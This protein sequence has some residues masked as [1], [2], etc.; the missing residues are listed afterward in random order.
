MPGPVI[1]FS[2]EQADVHHRLNTDLLFFAKHAPLLIKGKRP[3]EIVPWT[4][5]VGQRYLHDRLEDQIRRKGWVRVVVPKGRQVGVSTYVQMRFYH[6]VRSN[7][8]MSAFILS[9]EGKT[10]AKIF[11]MAEFAHDNIQAALRPEVGKSNVNQMTFP[12]LGSDYAVGTAGNENVGRGGTAQLFH[13]SEAAYWEHDYAI[14]DGALE[15]IGLVP[16]TEIILESTGNGP[17][18]LFYDKCQMALRTPPQGVYE[19]VFIPWYW[20]GDYEIADDPMDPAEL[21]AEEEE[22]CRHHF[23]RPFPYHS[24]PIPRAQQIRKMLWRRMKILDFATS[25]GGTNVEAGELKFKSVYP[26]APVEVFLATLVSLFQAA[27]IMAARRSTITDPDAPLVAGVDPAGDSDT[28]DRT[29]IVLRRGRHMEKVLTYPRMTPMRLAGIVA[30]DVIDKAGARMVFIDRGYGEGTIDRLREM[31]YA[32]RVVGVA[33]NERPMEPDRF[34]NKRSEM[35]FAFAKWLN[36]RDV[37]IP[38]SDEVHADLACVPLDEE[39]SN[40][41]KFIVSNSVLKKANGGRSLD[42]VAAGAL[43]FAYPVRSENADGSAAFRKV[44]ATGSGFR[45]AGEG[46][47]RSLSGRRRPAA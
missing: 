37:R 41:L 35:I 26:S 43:T 24:S 8:G 10:T 47:L 3:G 33:F 25:G 42:I 5:N 2:G 44:A 21:T 17:K 11:R 22:F 32:R 18:G 28:A 29:V 30:R 1:G 15:S 27:A 16:G 4:P 36:D 38:D 12:N 34:L 6:K 20:L 40:G 23:V 19:M 46:P 31:G 9:H 39:T 45:K 13:G 7:R 14:Q